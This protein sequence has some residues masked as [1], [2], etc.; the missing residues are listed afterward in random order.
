MLVFGPKDK[1]LGRFGINTELWTVHFLPRETFW[2]LKVNSF[3]EEPNVYWKSFDL[4]PFLSLS[5]VTKNK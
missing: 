4:G 1:F 2:G 3:K 5:W